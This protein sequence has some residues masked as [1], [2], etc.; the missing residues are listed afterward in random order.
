MSRRIL[1]THGRAPGDV[2]MLSAGVRDFKALFPDIAINVKTKFPELF[3]HNPHLDTTITRG[4]GCEEY[5][6]GYPTIQGCNDGYIHFTQAFL[7]DMISHADAAERLPITLGEFCASFCCGGDKELT[8]ND[9]ACEPWK[10]WGERFEGITKRA[11]RQFG[12]LHLSDEERAADVIRE[13]Y[14]VDAY[15]VVAPGGKRDCTAK[16]WDWR[17][18]QKVVDH[19]DGLIQFVVIGRGDHLLDM[20][21]GAVSFVDKTRDNLR[22][23]VPLVYHAHGCVSGVSFLMHLAAAVPPNPKLARDRSRKPCV[24]IYGGREPPGFTAYYTNHQVLHT[25][26]ALPCCD[27]GGCWQSRIVPIAKDPE[28]NNRMCHHTVERDGR[29]IQRCMDMITAEEVIRAIERYYDGGLYHYDQGGKSRLSA[30]GL[31]G[32]TVEPAKREKA[33]TY[34]R[35]GDGPWEINLLASLQSS[36]GGEQSAL[37]VADVLRGAGWKV[38]FHPWHTVHQNYVDRDI[39]GGA[40]FVDGIMASRMREGVP[41]LFYGNDQVGA[42]CEQ[43]EAVVAKSSAVIVGVNYVN[44][45]LPKCTWLA[46]TGKLRAVVFQ[47]REKLAEFRRDV[48]GFDDCRLVC[49]FGA[50]EL[51]RFCEVPQRRRSGDEDLVVL[52]HCKPDWR[53]WVTQQSEGTGEKIHRWQKDSI[54]ERDT[55]FYERLLSDCR[56]PVRFEFLEAHEEVERHFA[57]DERMAFHKWDS[58]P[59]PEFLARGHV[60]LYRTSN[61]WRDQYPRCVA[62]ALAAGLPVL[63]EPRDGTGDRVVHGDTGFLCMDY[64]QFCEALKKLRR[65]EDYRYHMGYEAKEWARKNLDPRRWADVV[66]GVLVGQ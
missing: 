45:P 31:T 63:T 4:D 46:R 27:N 6:V 23:L 64:D 41:L 43:G 49:L 16:M 40:P 25:N 33:R 61:A 58:L 62:E 60:Y 11:F 9:R 30:G 47:N 22:A 24:A 38:N 53:K 17:R 10:S 56:F 37:K 32:L 66:E 21:R 2:L 28:H 19:F 52:K 35:V 3:L 48:I 8:K 34:P 55:R 5:A 15:W 50:I 7:M 44:G 65:K 20:P 26:G 57:G 13:T 36:G 18:F 51:D 12:D 39:E 59:V 29:T 42:F 54:K 1:F 14:K